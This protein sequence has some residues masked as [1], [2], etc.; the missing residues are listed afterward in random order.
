[1][2]PIEGWLT[3]SLPR[4][5]ADPMFRRV[6]LEGLMQEATE[7]KPEPD[8][9]QSDWVRLA[10]LGVGGAV[11]SAAVAVGVAVGWR[12]RRSSGTEAA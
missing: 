6:L 5:Y 3:E 12:L 8:L 11:V 9:H 7:P 1:M 4:P 10:Y 2:N